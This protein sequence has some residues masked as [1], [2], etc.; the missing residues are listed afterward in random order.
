MFVY[1]N[2]SGEVALFTCNLLLS[3]VTAKDKHYLLC[4][5]DALHY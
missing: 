3:L 5:N 4:N 1:L 2:V